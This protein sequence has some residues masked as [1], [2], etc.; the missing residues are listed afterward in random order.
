MRAER[1]VELLAGRMDFR[2][3]LGN[4][5]LVVARA[6]A[7]EGDTR[8]A[9]SG[10]TRPSRRFD[11]LG[12]TSHLAAAWLARGDIVRSPAT[13]TAPPTTTARQRIPCKTSISR[14]STRRQ[15]QINHWR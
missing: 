9:T 1:A 11:A 5:Q 2:D 12:S 7:A 8:V 6:L 15:L 3:E 14:R 13:S 4:A 10:S